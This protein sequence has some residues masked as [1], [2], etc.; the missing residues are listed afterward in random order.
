MHKD[1]VHQMRNMMIFHGNIM[2]F[3]ITVILLLHHTG[4]LHVSKS[5]WLWYRYTMPWTDQNDNRKMY[6]QN[7]VYT[8]QENLSK[9][10]KCLIITVNIDWKTRHER[11]TRIMSVIIATLICVLMQIYVYMCVYV[12]YARIFV[13][14]S[15]IQ[16]D[17]SVNMWNKSVHEFD[18][19]FVGVCYWAN[20][21]M[22]RAYS[23]GL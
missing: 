5:S 15:Q 22:C 12:S 20:F 14:L 17:N 11:T 9:L 4:V 16:A 18:L 6:I 21:G 1:K 7:H 19:T 10:I 2:I 13:I 23:D 8:C 3:I